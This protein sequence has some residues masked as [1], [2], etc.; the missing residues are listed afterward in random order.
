MVSFL[1][2]LPLP[3]QAIVTPSVEASLESKGRGLSYRCL[4]S[5]AS[6]LLATAYQVKL[7]IPIENSSEGGGGLGR[8]GHPNWQQLGKNISIFH[9]N[10]IA[11]FA[12]EIQFAISIYYNSLIN[13]LTSSSNLVSDRN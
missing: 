13:M 5:L 11:H 7:V 8:I 6:P 2:V 9:R 12:F 3:H 10:L 4:G 1:T